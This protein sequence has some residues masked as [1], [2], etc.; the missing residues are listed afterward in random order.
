METICHRIAGEWHCPQIHAFPKQAQAELFN[1]VNRR[2]KQSKTWGV[3]SPFFALIGHH[4]INSIKGVR[5]VFAHRYFEDSLASLIAREQSIE[6]GP[7]RWIQSQAYAAF[8]LAQKA[9]AV[10]GVPVLHLQYDR[11]I[12]DTS[13]VVGELAVFAEVSP[14]ADQ[15]AAAVGFIN[16]SLRHYP[17]KNILRSA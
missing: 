11:L 6:E 12:D 15:Q 13:A 1:Y 4:I 2:N 3:K 17:H 7:L 14:T 16:P 10:R 9:A 8:C 5:V